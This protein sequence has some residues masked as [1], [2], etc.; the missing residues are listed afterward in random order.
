MKKW[1]LAIIILLC[2]VLL[3]ALWF[4]IIHPKLSWLSGERLARRLT[5]LGCDFSEIE[6]DP[7]FY[8]KLR[9]AVAY[10]EAVP[11]DRSAFVLFEYSIGYKHNIMVRDAVRKYYGLKPDPIEY[12]FG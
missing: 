4:F 11:D 5:W 8:E 2:V 7:D 3:A 9:Y 12:K 6:D 1:K 10:F